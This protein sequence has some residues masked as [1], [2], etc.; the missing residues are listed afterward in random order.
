MVDIE[1]LKQ[2]ITQ[3]IEPLGPSKIYLY[4]SYASGKAT[5]DSDV[6]LCII[7]SG[8]D[9]ETRT[10]SLSARRNLRDLIFKYHIGFDILTLTEQQ[11][12]EKGQ[13]FFTE[14]IINQGTLIYG[15]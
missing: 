7:K 2:E 4:G 15:E 1:N 13:K 5:D 10:L 9:I 12:E 3:R 6:D 8:D 11:I 14:E